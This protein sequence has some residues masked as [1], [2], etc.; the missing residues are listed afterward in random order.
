M[1]L[2]PG[3][4]VQHVLTEPEV[5]HDAAPLVEHPEEI[6]VSLFKRLVYSAGDCRGD[7]EVKENKIFSVAM[8]MASILVVVLNSR[9]ARMSFKEY[10]DTRIHSQHKPNCR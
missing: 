6:S 1:V 3:L 4:S 7:A 10:K 2:T 5:W 8:Q 9:R